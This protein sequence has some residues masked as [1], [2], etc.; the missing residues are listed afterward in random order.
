M[1]NSES[2]SANSDARFAFHVIACAYASACYTDV[3]VLAL[4][5]TYYL[6]DTLIWVWKMNFMQLIATNNWDIVKYNKY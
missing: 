6:W 2:I 4:V 1:Q 5:F 3:F